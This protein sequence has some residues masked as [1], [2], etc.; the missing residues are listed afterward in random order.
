MGVER[1]NSLCIC[2]SSL[3]FSRLRGDTVSFCGVFIVFILIKFL[4]ASLAY[5]SRARDEHFAEEGRGGGVTTEAVLPVHST[6]PKKEA[7]SAYLWRPVC[8][9]K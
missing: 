3:F 7:S 8:P 4:P 6:P 9:M 1:E 5:N 2:T